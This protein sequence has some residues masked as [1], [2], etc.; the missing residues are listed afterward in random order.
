MASVEAFASIDDLESRWRKLGE[1]EQVRAEVLLTDA[2]LMIAQ[3]CAHKGIDTGSL[4][5]GDIFLELCKVVCI[6][7]VKRMMLRPAD[8]PA[9]NAYQQGAGPYSMTLT[10]A[11]PTGDMYLTKSERKLLGV[12]QRTR[13]A[14]FNPLFEGSSGGDSVDQG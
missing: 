8:E 2:S 3:E 1:D 6:N 14:C 13:V 5:A 4:P 12:G 11:N 9:M 7:V 10:Y